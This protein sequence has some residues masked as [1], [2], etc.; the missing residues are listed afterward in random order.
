MLIM[1]V[2]IILMYGIGNYQGFL[3]E[4]QLFI[5]HLLVYSTILLSLSSLGAFLYLIVKKSKE[6]SAY[7]GYGMLAILGILLSWIFAFLIQITQGN[8]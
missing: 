3:V 6:F 4:T 7:L 2:L 8:I 5:V 1:N